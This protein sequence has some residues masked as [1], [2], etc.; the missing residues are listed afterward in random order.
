[1]KATSIDDLP[2]KM[3]KWLLLREGASGGMGPVYVAQKDPPS[4][5]GSPASRNLQVAAIKVLHR[6]LANQGSFVSMFADEARLARRISS[7]HVVETY[8]LFAA[9]GRHAI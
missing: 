4:S 5:G 2:R 3:G 6:H 8:E 7:R 1:M 9:S